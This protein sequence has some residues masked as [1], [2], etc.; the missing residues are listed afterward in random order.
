[1]ATLKQSIPVG[2]AWLLSTAALATACPNC[3]DAVP[4]TDAAMATSFGGGINASV[5]AMFAG[6]LVAFGLAARVMY[7]GARSVPVRIPVESQPPRRM[8]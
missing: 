5:Y 2:L 1:M 3:K 4:G 7:K 8:E 6:L